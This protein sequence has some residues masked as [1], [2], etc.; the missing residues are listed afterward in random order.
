MS[1][2]EANR[3]QFGGQHYMFK[4]YQHWDWVTDIGLHYL[5]ACPVKYISRWREKG[6]VEDL[7]KAVHYLEKAEERGVVSSAMKY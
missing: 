4:E 5:L 2:G 1:Q 6:G 3:K 7:K